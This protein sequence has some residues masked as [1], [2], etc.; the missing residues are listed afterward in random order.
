[1]RC[2]KG[3]VGSSPTRRMR[4]AR[5]RTAVL[6]LAAEGFSASDIAR[7]TSLP[8]STV[9]DWVTAGPGPRRKEWMGVELADRDRARYAYLLGAYLGDGHIVRVARSWCLRLYLDAAYP[10]IVNEVDDAVAKIS[11]AGRTSRAESPSRGSMV[12]VYSYGRHWLAAFPQHGP[13]KKHQRAIALADW[14]DVIVAEHPKPLLRGL[15]HSDG[16][17]S[18]NKVRVRGVEYAYPR[19]QFSNRSEDI[20][21]IFANACDRIGCGWTRMSDYAISVARRDDVQLMDEFIGPK[22]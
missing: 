17:R 4:P 12:V 18:L 19:Y 2:S 21:G 16:C 6:S 11:P 9:R 15:V 5:E 14:Q 20:L 3:L 7:R 22:A 1:M 13:G 10:G 8:R